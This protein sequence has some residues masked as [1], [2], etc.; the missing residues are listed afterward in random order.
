MATVATGETLDGLQAPLEL[1]HKWTRQL[2]AHIV[3][4]VVVELLAPR[5]FSLAL[6]RRAWLAFASYTGC[7]YYSNMAHNSS[8]KPTGGLCP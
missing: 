2:H 1:W 8:V 3:V 5:L 6:T 7:S 4:N